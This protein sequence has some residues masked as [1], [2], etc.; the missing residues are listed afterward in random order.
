MTMA[1]DQPPGPQPLRIFLNY[2]REDTAGY[3]GRLYDALVSR[4]PA[5][6]VF[7]DID[8][9]EPGVDFVEVVE[10]AVGACDVFIALIGQRWAEVMNER[11][12]RRLGDENDFVRLE[13]EAAL[14][15][16]IRIIPVLVQG[17]NMPRASELPESLAPLARRNALELSDHRWRYDL[18]Q[19]VQVLERRSP[20][21]PGVAPTIAATADPTSLG[22]PATDG[23]ENRPPA[24]SRGDR[25][26]ARTI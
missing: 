10:N 25:P 6:Q 16:K 15:R 14:K 22:V 19:L 4:F 23:G 5:D 1:S 3:A 21:V 18:Q 17:A 13:I 8:A 2:R 26:K 12:Q 11:G 7:I 9:I 24:R 20:P